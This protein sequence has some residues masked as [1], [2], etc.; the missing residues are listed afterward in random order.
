MTCVSGEG[1]RQVK[2]GLQRIEGLLPT[3][4]RDDSKK[5]V[6]ICGVTSRS[7]DYVKT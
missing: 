6:A 7:V 1:M 2:G 4:A 5:G 3:G